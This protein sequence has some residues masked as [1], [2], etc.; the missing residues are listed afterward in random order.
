MKNDMVLVQLLDRTDRKD[1]T[2]WKD[3][4]RRWAGHAGPGTS[5]WLKPGG[6]SSPPDPS[7]SLSLNG[8]RSLIMISWRNRSTA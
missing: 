5:D 7:P 1:R 3:W 4:K 2:D 8:R 6:C